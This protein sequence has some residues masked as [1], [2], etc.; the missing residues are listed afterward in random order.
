MEPETPLHFVTKT[1][2]MTTI[3]TRPGQVCTCWRLVVIVP[4]LAQVFLFLWPPAAEARRGPKLSLRCPP[5]AS[6]TGVG[7]WEDFLRSRTALVS[8][9]NTLS[10]R[11]RRGSGPGRRVV[12]YNRRHFSSLSQDRVTRDSALDAPPL[13]PSLPT[14]SQ[15]RPYCRRLTHNK[16]QRCMIF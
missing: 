5:P 9:D 16:S 3:I 4:S 11:R 13:D 10:L 8:S 15:P 6:Q 1:T 14:S 7:G 2:T 12:S